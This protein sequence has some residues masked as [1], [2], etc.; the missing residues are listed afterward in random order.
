MLKIECRTME[1]VKRTGDLASDLVKELF[2]KV[3]FR[4]KQEQAGNDAGNSKFKHKNWI[5]GFPASGPYR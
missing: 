5:Y 2:F 1:S 4:D 3:L